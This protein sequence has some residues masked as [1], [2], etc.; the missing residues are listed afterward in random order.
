MF[1]K[2]LLLFI[3]VS[4]HSKLLSQT[5]DVNFGYAKNSIVITPLM[6]LIEDS[7]PSIYYRRYLINDSTRFLSVRLGTEFLSNI[8]NTFSTGLTTQTKGLNLKVGL[9]YGKRFG[10]STLYYGGELSNSRYKGNGAIIYP[11]QN[12]LFNNNSLLFDETSSILDEATLNVFAIVGFV[13]FK[14]KLADRISIGVESGI[15]YGWYSSELLYE[16]PFFGVDSENYEGTL[17]QLIP[18]RFIFVE[19]DF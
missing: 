9:E 10:K 8:E 16:D 14:Y 3:L 1:R 6:G 5:K 12:A 2:I 7:K 19:F 11:D 13:G 15:A 4:V 18:N 17:S